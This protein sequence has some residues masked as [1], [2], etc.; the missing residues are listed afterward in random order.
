M[1]NA[2]FAA[3]NLDAH[4][5]ALDVAPEDLLKAVER[6]RSEDVFGANVTVPHKL[7]VIPL[8]DKLT[9]EAR[10]IG[11]VNTIINRD[12]SLTGHN[13]DAAGY[14]RALQDAGLELETKQAVV[15]G[16]GGAARA[17]V[18]ALL[19]LGSRVNIYNRSADKALKLAT[20]FSSYGEVVAVSKEELESIKTCVLVNTTSVGMELNGHDPNTSPLRVDLACHGEAL[21]ATSSTNLPKLG[22]CVRLK[23]KG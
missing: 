14:A 1:H 5:S 23:R 7:A 13:T 3:L 9:A 17:V 20:D 11:A 16:A 15:L 6:L 12:G 22:S 21:S 10:A 2:A 4:Y 19:K 8:L 18:Y